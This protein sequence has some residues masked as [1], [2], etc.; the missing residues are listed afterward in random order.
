MT[1]LEAILA[2]LAVKLELAL[3]PAEW[4]RNADRPEE[5]PAGGLAILRDGSQVEAEAMFSPLSYVIA[6][7]AELF[8]GGAD[9]AERDALISAAVLALEAD[10]T[11]GGLVSWLEPQAPERDIAEAEGADAPR[12]AT[13]AIRV[14]YTAASLAR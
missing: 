14:H 9:E 3:A 8:L 11:L 1:T 6:H 5:I 7:D 12:T 2:A 4:R 10:R 13:L